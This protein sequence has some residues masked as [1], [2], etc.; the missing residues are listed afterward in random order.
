MFLSI[1][2]LAFIAGIVRPDFFA[3]TMLLVL[4][5]EALVARTIRVMIISETMRLVILPLTVIYVAIRM[6]KPAAAVCLVSFP[7]ALVQGPI[8]PDLNALS[9][10]PAELVPVALI[11]SPIVESDERS[12]HA[13]LA[14]VRRTWLEIK[15]L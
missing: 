7:V 4:I 11:L 5:P 15:R 9:V 14:I 10:F 12:G 2:I 8:D 3:V 6:N 1:A 13:D